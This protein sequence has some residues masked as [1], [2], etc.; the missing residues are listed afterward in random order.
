MTAAGSVSSA[1]A[2]AAAEDTV[3]V[4]VVAVA[5][6]AAFAVAVVV[7]SEVAAFAVAAVAEGDVVVL[8]QRSHQEK[9]ERNQH[10]DYHTKQALGGLLDV[11][12][13]P[14]RKASQVY[15]SGSQRVMTE[16][17]WELWH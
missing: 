3:A 8:A 14:R 7:A 9:V 15:C 4:Y 13:F 6:A 12:C 16:Y 1:V 5:F 2:A 10:E 11:D 17:G